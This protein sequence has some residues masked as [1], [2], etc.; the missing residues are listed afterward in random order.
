MAIDC[1]MTQGTKEALGIKSHRIH[2]IKQQDKFK[3]GRFTVR[4]FESYHDAKEPVNFVIDI[5]NYRVAYITDTR[6]ANYIIPNMT[7]IL[8]EANYSKEL[9]IK[10][11]ANG[12]EEEILMK[13]IMNTHLS[14]EQTIDFLRKNDLSKTV[15]IYLIHLSDKNSRADLF[16]EMVEKETGIETYVC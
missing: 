1:Y 7:H 14:I 2:I 13:R 3:V 11:T 12:N 9:L 6:K 10:N 15:A 5:D 8:I 16:K 4:S